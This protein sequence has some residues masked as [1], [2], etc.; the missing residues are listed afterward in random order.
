MYSV[1]SLKVRLLCA[2]LLSSGLLIGKTAFAQ[3][4]TWTSTVDGQ[5]ESTGSWAGG[6]IADGANN[7][8]DFSTLDIVDQ[9]SPFYRA[10]IGL[11]GNRTI[12][13]LNFGDANPATPGAW[14]IYASSG[15]PVLTLAG[16]APSVTVNNMGPINTGSTIIN[17]AAIQIPVNSA[18]GLTKNGNGIL[19]LNQATSVITGAVHVNGG[20]LRTGTAAL[21]WLG[22][23]TMANGTSLES[24]AFAV[25]NGT[26]AAAVGTITIAAGGTATVRQNTLGRMVGISG[27]GSTLNFVM[28]NSGLHEMHGNWLVNGNLAQINISTDPAAATAGIFR[29]DVNRNANGFNGGSFA[30][31]RVNLTHAALRVRTNSQGNSIPIG[32]LSGASTGI[33]RGGE[34]GSAARYEIGSLNTDST[35]S[36]TID[37]T[38]GISINKL[39]TGKLTLAGTF[40]GDTTNNS[41]AMSGQSVARQGGVIRVTGGTLALTGAS[42]IPGG[43]GSV[44]T[45]VD[46]LPGAVFDVSG[47]PMTFSTSPLQKVQGTGTIRGTYNHDEGFIYPGDVASATAANEGSLSAGV[48]ATAG[49]IN[50]NGNLQMNGGTIRYDMSLNPA[51]GN[52]LVS[53]TGSVALNSGKVTPNFLAGVP[54]SGNYTVITAAGGFTGSAANITVD[55]PGRG[56]DPV[57]FI[58]GN[59]LM[60]SPADIGAGAALVWT[61]ANSGNWDVETTQNWTNSGSPDVFFNL[62]SVTFPEAAANKAVTVNALVSPTGTIAI[63]NTSPYTFSGTGAIIGNA[64]LTKTGSGQLTMTL[65]NSFSGPANVSGPVDIGGQAN[66]LGTG[67]LTL[68]NA[69]LKSTVSVG[70]S[71][72]DIP[73]GT[74][75]TIQ[76]DGAATA[77]SASNIPTLTGDGTLNLTSIVDNKYFG[78]FTTSGFTGT[79]NVF[80]SAPATLLGRVRIRAGQTNFSQAVVNL[81]SS[82]LSNQQGSAADISITVGIGELHGD[83]TSSITAFEGGSTP[84]DI[85]WE[86][87]ALNTN[88]DFAG[89]ISDGAGG[90][91]DAAISSITKVGTGTLALTGVNTYTGNTRVEGGTLSINNGFLADTSDVFISGGGAKLDLAF[92]GNDTIDALYLNGVPQAPGLYGATGLGSAFFL[93]TGLLQVTTLGPTLGVVGDYNNDGTVNAAD[94]TVWRDALGTATALA[95]RAPANTGNVSQ[96]DYDSWKANFGLTAGAGA[97][98]ASLSA[99]PEPATWLL[100]LAGFAAAGLSRRKR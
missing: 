71:T 45:T 59:S 26:G 80:P 96:A 77:G 92:G 51:S 85:V 33:L 10:A 16:T 88:S 5:W 63:N 31:T 44:L 18:A 56:S 53:V 68:N 49:T 48:V 81:T 66:G 22:A 11:S 47:T 41:L 12:G 15:A 70:N 36:G 37:G 25:A 72:L 93:G 38:G 57:A 74:T 50:F 40:L 60:F 79:L 55:F 67:A 99:V 13:H 100:L 34:A 20:G 28:A 54:T 21:D 23:H 78:T 2:A 52:D 95:N 7:T 3:N 14:E 97:S 86:I 64:G 39:G 84:P 58:Q 82:G 87:G 6:V 46:V 1:K 90:G 98:G 4:G 29:M 94:Y 30:N 19:S 73:A 75:S 89:V 8:A 76:L 91:G 69:S 43:F 65:A 27:A 24:G 42:A 61:G 83:S 9:G 62:D 17:D 35:F 32:E